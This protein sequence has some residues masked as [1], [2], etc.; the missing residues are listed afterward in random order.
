MASIA[1]FVR[2]AAVDYVSTEWERV[3]SRSYNMMGADGIPTL[4]EPRSTHPVKS[5]VDNS[6]STLS[7]PLA[8]PMQQIDV[9]NF[10]A[11]VAE[12]NQQEKT[13]EYF[14]LIDAVSLSLKLRQH[15]NSTIIDASKIM[16][17]VAARDIKD[18][19]I[20]TQM[21]PF[22]ATQKEKDVANF[23]AMVAALNDQE[24]IIG[25]SQLT[26]ALSL[27]L[28]L[29]QHVTSIVLDRSSTIITDVAARDIK[30]PAIITQMSPFTATQKEKDVANFDAMVAALNDQE[31]LIGHSQLIDALSLSL[32]L[33]QHV[34]STILDRSTIMTDVAAHDI[35]D[36]AIITHIC[37][38]VTT[39]Q[40]NDMANFDAM[41][42][43]L[44]ESLPS[45]PVTSNVVEQTTTLIREVE[46]TFGPAHNIKASTQKTS[47]RWSPK[48]SVADTKVPGL[49][50][51]VNRCDKSKS[52]YF[53]QQ[54][55]ARSPDESSDLWSTVS[56]DKNAM[57]NT[58]TESL[59]VEAT[60]TSSDPHETPSASSAMIISS[61]ND[62]GPYHLPYSNLDA[63][64][65][66]SNAIICQ[67][68]NQLNFLIDAYEVEMEK[69][70]T[71][72]VQQTVQA[73]RDVEINGR[74][75]AII[76]PAESLDF[77]SSVENNQTDTAAS[78]EIIKSSSI[79]QFDD[80]A[81]GTAAHTSSHQLSLFDKA[82]NDP[83]MAINAEPAVNNQ[84]DSTR[85]NQPNIRR[86][87]EI[88][89]PIYNNIL[90]DEKR[91][92]KFGQQ[93]MVVVADLNANVVSV[94]ET[95]RTPSTPRWDKRRIEELLAKM[96]AYITSPNDEVDDFMAEPT[97]NASNQSSAATFVSS[98]LMS[99]FDDKSI[100][101]EKVDQILP[102]STDDPSST[103]T[104]AVTL[105]ELA[106]IDN[107]PTQQI[108]EQLMATQK[109]AKITVKKLDEW[110][111]SPF[112][113]L[114]D[115][116]AHTSSKPSSLNLVNKVVPTVIKKLDPSY[117]LPFNQ[118]SSTSADALY[119]IVS[120]PV[121]RKL[122]SSRFSPLG[123]SKIG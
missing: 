40:E 82:I 11:M 119:N 13:I 15:V 23:D 78:V 20:I 103:D 26:D 100:A 85:F 69:H 75:D 42:A 65:D 34:T 25:H 6:Q 29:R 41:I 96:D 123:Q 87:N 84:F 16:T 86:E 7:A 12:L 53:D 97:I 88:V 10:D 1:P 72:Q 30:D 5:N 18:P 101:L 8:A 121:V 95:N 4:V 89:L 68:V 70:Q 114:S 14:Q 110:R 17:D 56:Y 113:Q 38:F 76:Y 112:E 50:L 62:K 67:K 98:C 2:S 107:T 83:S 61:S 111:R 120:T 32:K 58:E 105:P 117:Y 39:Q 51:T 44:A 46:S 3:K 48:S 19:A 102:I 106:T 49:T 74:D 24:Q 91:A 93:V 28:K 122:D 77:K 73:Y 109:V 81:I 116:A 9:A 115:D 71:D 31:Q 45:F 94:C 79:S 22:T 57:Y 37:S 92:V 36:P 63:E 55:V 99:Q 64:I 54:L 35:K 47:S 90:D 43:V 80:A 118:P 60:L 104:V 108:A 66:K 27:S 21:S 33:R 52:T 59:V